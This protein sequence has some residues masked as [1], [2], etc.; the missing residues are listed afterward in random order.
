MKTL[1]TDSM[2]INMQGE[3]FLCQ[4]G[5]TAANIQHSAHS[6]INFPRIFGIPNIHAFQTLLKVVWDSG[7]PLP[8]EAMRDRVEKALP[9]TLP[10]TGVGFI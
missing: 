2:Q 4:G 8:T 9:V 3:T 5:L 1:F 6:S 7:T 10:M